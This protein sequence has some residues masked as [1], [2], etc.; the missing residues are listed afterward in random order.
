MLIVNKSLHQNKQITPIFY[1]KQN[2]PILHQ[3]KQIT[4]IFYEKQNK[5]IFY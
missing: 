3:N 2:K 4:P 5:P 1:D